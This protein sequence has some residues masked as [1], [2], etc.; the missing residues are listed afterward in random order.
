M[1]DQPDLPSD[2]S[3]WPIRSLLYVPATRPEWVIKAINTE[4]E[5]VILDLEDAVG[6]SDKLR[7]RALVPQEI[8]NSAVARRPCILA[9]EPDVRRRR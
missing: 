8:E 7:A 9:A 5:A 1:T 2:T 4:A 3:P 6:P